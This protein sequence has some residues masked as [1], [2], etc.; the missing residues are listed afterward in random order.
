MPHLTLSSGELA[1]EK[2]VK[3]L[4]RLPSNPQTE[5][6]RAE[7]CDLIKLD[8]LKLELISANPLYKYKD[9][10]HSEASYSIK[11]KRKLQLYL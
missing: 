6:T 11:Y 1:K 8:I 7:F 10:N 2:I 4:L 9:V 3:T 5:E